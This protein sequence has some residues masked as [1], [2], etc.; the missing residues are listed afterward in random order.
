MSVDPAADELLNHKRAFL[1]IPVFVGSVVF[2]GLV[3]FYLSRRLNTL[4]RTQDQTGD[5]WLT[6]KAKFTSAWGLLAFGLT[7]A[8]ASFHLVKALDYHWFSTMF[9]VYFFAGNMISSLALMAL[10]FAL[11]RG[12]GKLEGLVTSEHFH[13][14]GKLMLGF[15]VFWA[16]I[17]FS[18]YFLIWYANLPEETGWFRI[19]SVHGWETFGTILMFGHF[20]APFLVLLFRGTKRSPFLLATVAIWLI[21]MHAIDVFWQIRPIVYPDKMGLSWVD[22][23][24]LLGPLALF[25]GLLLKKV[26]QGPLIPIKDPR[27]T[28]ALEHKNYV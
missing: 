22:L 10:L 20:I 4:S 8:F 15:T 14:L 25:F 2:Y 5:R 18:Q 19:R 6:N 12:S 24:G 13:D 26:G 7:C 3:W 27:L 16:Y 9:G 17:A 1:N 11:I 21:A 23:A 28:E